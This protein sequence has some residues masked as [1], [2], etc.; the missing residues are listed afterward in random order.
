MNPDR[1]QPSSAAIKARLAAI[2]RAHGA[3]SLRV[4][5]AVPD[6]RTHE[7]MRNA[8]ARGYFTTWAYDDG[9]ARAASD[10]NAV[11]E[12]ARS[13][14]CLAF[15]YATR[16]PRRTHLQGRV[17]NYAWSADYHDRVRAALDAVAAE[18]DAIAGTSVAKV[19]CDTAPL[20]ERAYAA[21]AGLGWIGK[22]TNLI[23]P[24][25]GSF[26][27]LGEVLTTLELEPDAPL[28][29]HCGTC[30][31]CIDACP[32]GALRGDYTID[33][34][35]CIGDLNQRTDVIPR[36]MRPLIGDWVWGCDLCQ[37]ACPPTA[38]AG[39]RGGA[40]AAPFDDV[41]AAP[42]LSALLK[43][44]SGEFKRRYSRTA[45]GWRGA[46]V[47]RRN[48]AIAL[49]NALDRST[50]AGLVEVLQED[51]NAL[52]RGAAAWALGRIGS[53]RALAGLQA[54]R[55]SEDDASVTEEIDAAL[56]PYER[57]DSLGSS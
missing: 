52:V 24:V 9:Y 3:E 27:F 7:R 47:L 12:G 16:E 34:T 54:A 30:A 57:K 33:A 28:K 35:R 25:L 43:L 21:A 14:V 45:M 20:A 26:V 31:R 8:F 13:I 39:N 23:A 10:P 49:G 19:A 6:E 46:A 32:T 5:R 17:S 22:H 1:S 15:P 40:A 44:R 55:R 42:A 53:P 56:E 18:L 48:A 2:A 11:L 38:I 36:E 4:A 37:L 41:T 29:K 50:V 51:P